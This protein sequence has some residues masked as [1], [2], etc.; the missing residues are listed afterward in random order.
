MQVAQDKAE[1]HLLQMAQ[2]L[3]LAQSLQ[4]A[5][6]LVVLELVTEA[7]AVDSQVA[8]VEEA[9]MITLQQLEGQEQQTKVTREAMEPLE[10]NM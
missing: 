9:V 6:V 7:D 8:Q 4:L 2:T 10:T 5:E 3:H 1:V